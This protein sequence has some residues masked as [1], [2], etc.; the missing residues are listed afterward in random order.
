MNIARL[1]TATADHEIALQLTE[2]GA[3]FPEDLQYKSSPPLENTYPDHQMFFNALM[4]NNVDA[5][6]SH[7][8]QKCLALTEGP[9]SQFATEA[10]EILIDFLY[11]LD[12]VDEAIA[13]A[14][15]CALEPSMQTGLAPDP[16]E[17]AQSPTQFESVLAH[18]QQQ[19]DLLG[20]S[21]ALL[22]QHESQAAQ[23]PN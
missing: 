3:G 1:T 10:N 4:G 9:N 2:Y 12:R 14:L 17:M 18:F 11:R 19:D 7:F 13:H 21:V 23:K 22:K 15:D 20:Y 8:K 6:V 16:T 5:A